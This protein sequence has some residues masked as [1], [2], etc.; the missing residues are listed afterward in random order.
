VYQPPSVDVLQIKIHSPE[1]LMADQFGLR[2]AAGFHK[3]DDATGPAH[4]Y[5]RVAIQLGDGEPAAKSL[6][7]DLTPLERL[8]V[9]AARRRESAE[10]LQAKQH[11]ARKGERWDM[12]GCVAG[13]APSVARARRASPGNG[14]L[15]GA[16]AVGIVIVQ[17]TMPDLALTDADVATVVTE[18]QNGLSFFIA[19]N[20]QAGISF[21]Y[22]IQNVTLDLPA[23]PDLEPGQLEP[24]WRDP[25]MQAIGYGTGGSAIDDYVYDLREN[26]GCQWSYIAYFT[27]Y[28]LKWFAYVPAINGGYVV[29]DYNVQGWGPGNIDTVFAHESA[30]IFG[31]ADE[32]AG[33]ESCTAAWTS[34]RFGIHNA[35]CELV[36][37]DGGI[38]CLM[39]SNDYVL[40]DYTPAHL[41]WEANI[42]LHNF[43]E[44]AGSWH[45]DKHPR[46][47]PDLTG[48]GRADLLGFGDDGVWTARATGAGRF[49]APR[50]VVQEFAYNQGWRVEKHP[51]FVTDVAGNRQ[52]GIVGFGDDGVWYAPGTGDGGFG[53]AGF[54]IGDLGYN[55]G[56]RVETHAR[57]LAD[58]TGDHRADIVGCGTA[59]VWT[60][61]SNGSGFDPVRFVLADFGTDTGWTAVRHP[62]LLADVTGDGRADLVGFGDAGVYVATS[63]GD[64]TFAGARFVLADLGWDHGWRTDKHPRLL[65]N[66]GGGRP[67]ADI[68]GFGDAGAYVC[69]ANGDGTFAPPVLAVPDFGYEQGWRVAK[70]PRFLADTTGDGRLDIV[71]CGAAGVYIARQLADGSFEA[72]FLAM[73]DFGYD[74]NWRV[75]QHPRV[76]AD[77]DGNA[78]ADVVGFGALGVRIARF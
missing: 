71:G 12:P 19:R 56:W 13:P 3:A 48:D 30:H 2:H 53:P 52:P 61:L 24:Y 43:G 70:H 16:V 7:A 66:L 74:Q 77:V 72:P 34:Q 40:C 37:V 25:A 8:G 42:V 60:A 6:P 28:P 18:V 20:P 63:N 58:I 31:A 39:K 47:A 76:L 10:Y 4:R 51:R 14:Y 55:Q 62:R 32:Y 36:A 26:A 35:N 49:T 23:R 27:K 5:G 15:E 21:S 17:G 41:G 73:K 68:V 78:R 65:A 54:V 69:R 50:M 33:A 11:R 29:M 67:V 64:G 45:V 22:D 46:L 59:G 44:G 75:A 57:V 1:V 9:E 38:D